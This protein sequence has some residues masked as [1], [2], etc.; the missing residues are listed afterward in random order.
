MDGENF[1]CGKA[2]RGLVTI[3]TKP[4]RDT[5]RGGFRG[6]IPPTNSNEGSIFCPNG[7]YACGGLVA[8]TP[9]EIYFPGTQSEAVSEARF[10]SVRGI[11][12]WSSFSLDPNPAN[13]APA[14]IPKGGANHR[15]GL[16]LP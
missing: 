13:P 10:E 3:G 15:Q 6:A 16:V 7:Y 11:L 5:H 4:Q 9:R 12:L 1:I 2:C 14:T 8:Q